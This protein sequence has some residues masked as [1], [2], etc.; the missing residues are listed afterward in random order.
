[1]AMVH[2][3]LYRSSDIAALDIATYLRTITNQILAYQGEARFPTRLKIDVEQIPVDIDTAIPLGLITNELLSNAIKYAFPEGSP[4]TVSIRG[5]RA[6]PDL[7]EFLFSDNGVGMPRDFDWRNADSLGLRL[8]NSL[9]E[10]MGADIERIEGPGTGFRIVF[11]IKRNSPKALGPAN[12]D[13]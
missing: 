10:Q 13:S 12:S 4:G 11:R 6:G 8:V 1:M 2:E 7:Y 5:K 3:R 9:V